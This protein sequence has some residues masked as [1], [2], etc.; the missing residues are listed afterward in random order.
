[1]EKND[2]K[3]QWTV[4]VYED[5][6]GWNYLLLW[7]GIPQGTEGSTCDE[8]QARE[9]AAKLLAKAKEGNYFPPEKN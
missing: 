7:N 4:R 2:S 8:G 9:S 3:N 6:Y 1:M 5:R